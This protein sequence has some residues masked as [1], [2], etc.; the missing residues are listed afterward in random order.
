MALQEKDRPAMPAPRTMPKVGIMIA[1]PKSGDAPPKANGADK[2]P[3]D[4]KKDEGGKASAEEALVIRAD[5]GKT[6]QACENYEPTDGS[7]S[8]VD[9]VYSPDDRCLRYFEKLGGEGDDDE[10]DDQMPAE[11]ADAGAPPPMK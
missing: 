11:D 6:C 9:G 2:P 10:Q 8:A 7:C 1:T 5:D 3:A 4:D